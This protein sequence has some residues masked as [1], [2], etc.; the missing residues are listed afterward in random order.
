VNDYEALERRMLGESAIALEAAGDKPLTEAAIRTLA[1]VL[2]ARHLGT[3]AGVLDHCR[4]G[5]SIQV[6][7]WDMGKP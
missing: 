3:I 7:A 5:D 2:I 1:L 4:D 6:A